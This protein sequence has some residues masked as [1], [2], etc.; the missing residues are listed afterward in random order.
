MKLCMSYISL[1]SH[2]NNFRLLPRLNCFVNPNNSPVS[3]A[4]HLHF[5]Q[6]ALR[7]LSVSS[8]SPISLFYLS[9][10]NEHHKCRSFC[11]LATTC[12]QLNC[13]L[14]STLLLLVW[15]KLLTEVARATMRGMPFL[16]ISTSSPCHP[17]NHISQL[18]CLIF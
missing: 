1:L 7:L 5:Q 8:L 15:H 11:A 13:L 3:R 16:Q 2:P 14:P 6:N 17:L 9:F 12:W 18:A 10:R 4:L